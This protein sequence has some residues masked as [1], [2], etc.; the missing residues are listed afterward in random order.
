MD[1]SGRINDLGRQYIGA[2]SP[3]T[4]VG[5]TPGVVTGGNGGQPSESGGVGDPS[6]PLAV[7]P[8]FGPLA[9]AFFVLLLI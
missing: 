6:R 4:T 8:F 7:F 3:N 9:A 2:I 1:T 5:Y